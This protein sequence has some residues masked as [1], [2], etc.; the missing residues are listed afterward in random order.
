[1]KP[2]KCKHRTGGQTLAIMGV[3]QRGRATIVHCV[4][5]T[6][7]NCQWRHP[8]TCRECKGGKK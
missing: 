3:E 1:M 2:D 6:C 7:D 4:E 8:D 5:M